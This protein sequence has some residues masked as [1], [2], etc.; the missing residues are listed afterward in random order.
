MRNTVILCVLLDKNRG[1][2]RK[3][4]IIIVKI[5]RVGSVGPPIYQIQF[6]TLLEETCVC[7][8]LIC[9]Q[10]KRMESVYYTRNWTQVPPLWSLADF[11]TEQM[12]IAM[13][14]EH[15]ILRLVTQ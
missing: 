11:A 4:F 2:E 15:N 3:R 6:P 14:E 13:H 8:V 9:A 5:R 7:T 12:K 10:L 1:K